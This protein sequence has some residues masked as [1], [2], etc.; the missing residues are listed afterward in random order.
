MGDGNDPSLIYAE[1][2]ALWFNQGGQSRTAASSLENLALQLRGLRS[3]YPSLSIQTSA[4]VLDAPWI[5]AL[6]ADERFSLCTSLI[7]AAS[8]ANFV[9]KSVRINVEYFLSPDLFI[10][11]FFVCGECMGPP[12]NIHGGCIFSLH[13]DSVIACMRIRAARDFGVKAC[14]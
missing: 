4:K 13:A 2:D 6:A 11:A 9:T 10:A 1:C 3:K 12:P 5:A 14:N 7:A 8:R